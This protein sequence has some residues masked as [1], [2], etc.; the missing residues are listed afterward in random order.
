MLVRHYRNGLIEEEHDGFVLT[1]KSGYAPDVPYYMRSCAKPL[2]ASLVIDYNLDKIY[3]L[4]N[5]EIALICAS[6]TGEKCHTDIAQSLMKKF[7]TEYNS[8]KCGIHKPLSRTKQDEMLFSKEEV[9]YFHNNCIGK[10]LMFLA[11]CKHNNWDI[12][13]YDDINNPLQIKVREKINDLC[14]LKKN[15]YPIAKDG[16]GVPI[17]SMPL[18]NMLFG[19]IN[20]FCDT[21]YRKIRTAFRKYPYIIGGEKRIETEI[22]QNSQNLVAKAGAGGLCIVVNTKAEDGVIVKINDCNM[23]TRRLVML[24]A[25][26]KLGWMDYEFSKEIKTLHDETIGEIKIEL[27]I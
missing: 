5:K 2:Q 21:K 27:P 18:K 22:M 9:T 20:L 17:I 10:H 1:M 26:N 11:L 13:T 12:K 8:I 25:L 7:K 19:Y 23:D 6:H 16:C 15:D 14:G 4:T 3:N 24:E